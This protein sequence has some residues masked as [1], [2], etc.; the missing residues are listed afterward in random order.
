MLADL[1]PVDRL[2]MLPPAYRRALF[3]ELGKTPGLISD[4]RFDW[5]RF[6]ARPEQLITPED[7]ATHGLIVVAGSRGEGKTRTIVETFV[8]EIEAG[9]AESPRIFAATEADVDKVVVHGKQSGIMTHLPPEAKA[10]WRW[11]PDEGPAGTIK[12]RRRDGGEIEIICFSVHRP[13]TAVSHAGDL[14]LYDDVAKWGPF[15]AT[16]WAHARL[17]CREGYACGLVAT[18]RRGTALLKQLLD[19]DMEGVLVK[20]L[21]LGGNRGNLNAAWRRRMRIELTKVV[22][23]LVRQELD[24]E[25][26]SA[27]SPFANLPWETIHI[28]TV[29]RDEFEELV[30]AVDPSDGKGGTHDEWGIGAAGRRTDKHC[31]VLEDQSGSYD[32]AEAGERIL[33]LCERRGISKIIVEVNRGPR[34]LSAIKAA[35]LARELKRILQNPGSSPRPMPELIGVVARDGKVLRAGPVRVLYLDGLVHHAPGLDVLDT[36]G[37]EERSLEKQMREWDPT[38]ALKRPR[39]D[40]RIDWLVHALTYLAELG[41]KPGE[42]SEAEEQRLAEAQ[43]AGA[44]NM[45]TA[46]AARGRGQTPAPNQVMKVEGAPPGDARYAGL[47][48]VMRAPSWRTRTVL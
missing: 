15:A 29:N 13:E 34:V 2:R 44:A 23:D 1:A 27:K 18:T 36:R 39:M 28:P 32:D 3:D 43:C 24:D 21:R 12:V 45:M 22:G 17:S 4:L 8:R 9:R 10:R 7:I 40:D 16:A 48:A 14:D 41:G 20:N 47:P 30:C 5:E 37:G 19:G 11:C 38:T 25:D 35:H 6:W 31:V 33:E 46:M 26:I 42:M